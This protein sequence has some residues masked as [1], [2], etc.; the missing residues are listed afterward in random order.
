MAAAPEARCPDALNGEFVLK[1]LTDPFSDPFDAYYSSLCTRF[2]SSASVGQI[3]AWECFYNGTLFPSVGRTSLAIYAC[4]DG[5]WYVLIRMEVQ[6]KTYAWLKQYNTKPNCLAFSDERIE[7]LTNQV[8]PCTGVGSYILVSAL[9]RAIEST[10]C[11]IGMINACY[12]GH[13]PRYFELTISGLAGDTGCLC[14]N[15]TCSALNGTYLL[16][17]GAGP[18]GPGW[19]ITVA[20]GCLG[21]VEI[22]WQPQTGGLRFVKADGSIAWQVGLKVVTGGKCDEWNGISYNYQNVSP[23]FAPCSTTSGTPA[24]G[25]GPCGG[26]LAVDAAQP[27]RKAAKFVVR[28]YHLPCHEP[29]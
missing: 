2:S 9:R 14:S 25:T 19:S 4:T 28:G 3:C 8:N 15:A 26:T 17:C 7:L 5:K 11:C 20:S 10:D 27:T 12:A 1:H 24:G 23:P 22:L 18:F 13:T 6:G 16:K 21:I 29:A